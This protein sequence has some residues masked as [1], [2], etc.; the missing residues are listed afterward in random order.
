[1]EPIQHGGKK[2]SPDR[3]G[4]YRKGSSTQSDYA[5]L[6]RVVYEEHYGPIPKGWHVHH[7]DGD[8]SNNKPENL[9]ALPASEHI[10]KYHAENIERAREAAMAWH[11]SPEGLE[12][13]SKHAKA[14]I[15]DRVYRVRCQYCGDEF[16]KSGT[17][18]KPKFCSNKCKSASRR[19]SGLDSESRKCAKCGADFVANKYARTKHCSRSCAGRKADR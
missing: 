18:R 1:M 16:E 5:R 11:A 12:W 17:I 6:H 2:Y 14:Q 3:G 8:K 4:Y 19:R 10:R 13:H 15:A 7:R 9:E